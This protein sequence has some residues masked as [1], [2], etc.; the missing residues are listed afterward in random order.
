MDVLLVFFAVMFG[1]F[2]ALAVRVSA[3]NRVSR[4]A[5]AASRVAS[6]LTNPVKEAST[7]EKSVESETG[8]S[9]A[10]RASTGS[11]PPDATG[12]EL[13][14]TAKQIREIYARALQDIQETGRG[15]LF[16]SAPKPAHYGGGSAYES[17]PPLFTYEFSELERAIETEAAITQDDLDRI[18]KDI[19]LRSK[20]LDVV[21]VWARAT[22]RVAEQLA[23][24]AKSADA[25]NPAEGLSSGPPGTKSPG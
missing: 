6:A 25:T 16:A 20:R 13:S 5:L 1:A 12:N 15:G 11:L 3:A 18:R 7:G 19:E 21:A 8:S 23:V 2:A 4:L 17:R 24:S 22:A 14:E 9:W 10:N